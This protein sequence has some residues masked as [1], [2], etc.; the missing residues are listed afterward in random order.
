ME[1]DLIKRRIIFPI[2]SSFIFL[3]LF[4][5]TENVVYESIKPLHNNWAKDSVYTFEVNEQQINQP[6]NLFLVLRNNEQ[7]KYSNIYFF[8]TLEKPDGSKKIDTLQYRLANPDG[9][10]IGKGM[11]NIKENLLLY[12]ENKNFSDTG[13]YKIHVQHGMRTNELKGL[14]NLGLIIQ[15]AQTHE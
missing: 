13:A 7:Y 5:C 14:E 6:Q 3:A 11:G 2:L 8:I 10:W 15:K 9:S 12:L 4:S 1:K